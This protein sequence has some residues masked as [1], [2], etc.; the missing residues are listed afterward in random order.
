MTL[1]SAIRVAIE[2]LRE[3]EN[4]YPDDPGDGESFPLGQGNAAAAVLERLLEELPG[5]LLAAKGAK[6]MLRTV[7]ECASH[8]C[9]DC[10]EHAGRHAM[11]L[12]AALARFDPPSEERT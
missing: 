10:R 11:T 6:S 2:A 3:P 8:D 4:N 1:D 5:V 12:G 7:N 9:E